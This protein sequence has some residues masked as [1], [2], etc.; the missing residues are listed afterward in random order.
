ML[1]PLSEEKTMNEIFTE[2]F[3]IAILGALALE[4]VAI[5]MNYLFAKIKRKR[6]KKMRI[7]IFGSEPVHYD[8]NDKQTGRIEDVVGF[9]VAYGV[10]DSKDKC[11]D[12][13]CVKATRCFAEWCSD[14]IGVPIDNA[15]I[16]YDRNGRAASLYDPTARPI[17]PL[18]K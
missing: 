8:I 5:T 18:V 3:E 7:V 17:T 12:M 13:Q 10:Y 15:E 2:R 6:A 14:N 4:I 9:K 1:P 16:S 11:R